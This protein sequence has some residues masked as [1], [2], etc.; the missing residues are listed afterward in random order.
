VMESIRGV[1]DVG[2]SKDNVVQIAAARS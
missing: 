2:P 1:L